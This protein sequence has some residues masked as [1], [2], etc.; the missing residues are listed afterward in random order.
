MTYVLT[1]ISAPAEPAVTDA[2]LA[3]VRASTA[4]AGVPMG[5]A[6][7]LAAGVACDLPLAAAPPPEFLNTVSAAL[8]GAPVDAVSQPNADRRK[9]L[10]VADMDSTI[11]TVECLDELA[12]FAGQRTRVAAITERAMR[13]E[14]NFEAA[15]RERVSLLRNLPETAL[16]HTYDERV[17]YTPGA[18][19]LV[20]TMRAHGARTVLV[21]GGFKY[22]TGRVA[23]KLGF[24]AHHAN[25]LDIA[26]GRLTGKVRNPILGK[27]AKLETLVRERSA[28]GLTP[29][30]VLAVGDGANDLDMLAEA[31]LGVAYHAKP[32]VA[33]SA[34]ARIDHADLTALL[35]LQGYR[36]DEIIR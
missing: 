26:D 23:A 1:L 24:D 3:A 32:L 5:D 27:A 21:S 25:D 4:A 34:R 28:L 16:A 9:R 33:R 13:G 2:V 10:L 17:R 14:L 35:Y 22:F 31:G 12:D 11:L 15:L 36:E 6:D 29:E 19:E 20:A 18:A 7:W 8:A 30:A